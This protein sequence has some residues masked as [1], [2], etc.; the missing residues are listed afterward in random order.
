MQKVVIVHERG[1]P[2]GV[3][4]SECEPVGELAD[5]FERVNV[6]G[7]ESEHRFLDIQSGAGAGAA[8]DG[9]G[10]DCG[11]DDDE[12]DDVIVHGGQEEWMMMH[13]EE[14]KERTSSFRSRTTVST[15]NKRRRDE[16]ENSSTIS[17]LCEESDCESNSQPCAVEQHG[18]TSSSHH[19]HSTPSKKH[20]KRGP[21]FSFN[22]NVALVAAV[23]KEGILFIK[24]CTQIQKN[25]AWVWLS[26]AVHAV[27]GVERITKSS[28]LS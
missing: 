27:G 17:P 26:F 4:A 1:D 11:D 9:V 15:T 2:A 24:T 25:A 5:V 12:D 13:D 8:L 3:A 20:Y 28:S 21:S 19:H 10:V 16:D 7:E 18:S 14:E 22:E 6:C 23:I